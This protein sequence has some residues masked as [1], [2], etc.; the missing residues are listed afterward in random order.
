MSGSI[1]LALR[2]LAA[3]ALYGF[4]GWALTF[5]YREVRRQSVVLS[6]RRVPGISIM[7][8]QAGGATSM[9]YFSQ[10]EITVG[11]DPGCDIPLLDETVSAR[12]AHLTYHHGQ[13]WL[14]DL[15]STNGTKLNDLRITTPTVITSGDEI[16]C[17][18]IGLSISL[19][20]NV[21]IEPTQRIKKT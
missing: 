17:G 19:S 4:L 18:S 8:K 6:N 14:E 21:V 16:R 10:A 3:L 5:M 11:R 9:R 15:T 7:V 2:L 20:E 1:A 13:W 12:H